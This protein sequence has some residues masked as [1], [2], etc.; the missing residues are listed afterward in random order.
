[1]RKTFLAAGVAAFALGIS[2][3]AQAQEP[4][5]EVSASV[6]PTKAGTKSK[7]KNEKFTI[8][9]KNDPASKTTAGSIKITLPS[10][11]KLS[12]KGLKQCTASDDQMVS[13][14]GDVCKSSKAGSGTANALVLPNGPSVSF[15]VTSFVGKNELLFVLKVSIGNNYVVHGKISGRTMTITI[16]PDLQQPAPGLY[17]ALVDL[18]TTIS[19]KKGKNYL[20]SSTGCKS[21]KHKVNVTVGYAPNPAAPPKPSASGS[22]DAKCS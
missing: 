11:L 18:K 13:T 12:T 22:A 8:S 20:F 16:T 14:L 5:I 6:S 21:K 19:M 7:P 9:V 2:G 3:V 4:K 1:L 15:V 17:A 10:T